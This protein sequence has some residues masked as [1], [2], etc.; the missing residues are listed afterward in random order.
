MKNQGLRRLILFASFVSVSLWTA[1]CGKGVA[2]RQNCTANL[3]MIAGAKMAW[4]EDHKRSPD[5]LPV[6]SDL[7]GPTNYIR[8]W[9]QCPEGGLYT[10]GKLKEPPA[11]S[12]PGHTLYPKAQ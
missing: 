7:V 5:D 12:F 3:K 8:S 6:V 4:A 1:G 9:P 10:I 11:C 2:G